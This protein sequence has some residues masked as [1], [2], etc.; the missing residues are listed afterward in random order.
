MTARIRRRLATAVLA[1]VVV[2]PGTAQPAQATDDD[3]AADSVI[4]LAFTAFRA[5]RGGGLS[6]EDVETLVRE[7]VGAVNAVQNETIGHVDGLEAATVL[8]HTREISYDMEDY[9]VVRQEEIMLWN[10]GQ[11]LGGYAN[12]AYAKYGAVSSKKA[13]DQIGLAANTIYPITLV[14]RKDAGALNGLP[15]Y[16]ADYQDLNRRIVADLEPVCT[17]RVREGTPSFISE[18]HYEC[19]AANGDTSSDYQI[20]N[21]MTGQWLRG[22]VDLNQ[23]KLESAIDS[24]WVVAKELLEQNP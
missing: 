9:A 6:A 8:G 23:L 5:F 21:D 18:V 3:G 4:T 7:V 10:F 13:K 12:N 1:L 17:S 15:R 16:E 20:R 24:A 14:V 2:V 19:V 11:K 22:P